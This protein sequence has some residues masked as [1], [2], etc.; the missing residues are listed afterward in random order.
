MEA[1]TITEE[2][3]AYEGLR[4]GLEADHMGKWVLIRDRKLISIFDSFE[5]AAEEA[6]KQFG[7]GPYLIRQIGAPPVTLPASVMYRSEYATDPLR[8][9]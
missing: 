2:I 5:L 1:T 3:D 4:Q 9:R 8:V 7:R 6:V